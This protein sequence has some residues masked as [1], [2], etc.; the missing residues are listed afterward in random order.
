MKANLESVNITVG[1]VSKASGF[2]VES[3]A[4][5]IHQSV[6][7]TLPD[8]S[9]ST[10]IPIIK[11]YILPGTTI[12]SDC[13]KAYGSLCIEGYV[14][15]TVNH[16]LEFVSK[17]GVHT[18]TIESRWNAVKKSL[19]RYGTQKS[20]YESYFAEYCIRRKFFDNASDKFLACL[21]LVASVYKSSS[22]QTTTSELL[23]SGRLQ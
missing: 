11:R 20:L 15:E 9:A 22:P 6:F 2:L 12:L 7:V 8:R 3:N 4:T 14:H 16:S 17:S 10:L 23:T 5:A 1:N 13:W 18:N 19:P 21:R